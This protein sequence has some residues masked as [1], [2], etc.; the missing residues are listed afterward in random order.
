MGERVSS[1]NEV[2]GPG[3]LRRAGEQQAGR[4]MVMDGPRRRIRTAHA[5]ALPA[6]PPRSPAVPRSARRRRCQRPAGSWRP[7]R[8]THDSPAQAPRPL[9]QRLQAPAA[10]G[11][12]GYAGQSRPQPP[13][14]GEQ[15]RAGGGGLRPPALGAAPPRRGG[16]LRRG[17][18]AWRCGAESREARVWDGAARNSGCS[19][20]GRCKN[21][22]G[23]PHLSSA[24][25]VVCSTYS[26][27]RLLKV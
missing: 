25:Q 24:S 14:G 5:H 9:P 11:R 7:G 8:L 2:K 12:V 18:R 22:K 4:G 23:G 10:R 17:R 13:A 20:Q 15:S 21:T 16:L 1:A 3:Q 6:T 27:S 19:M 26:S